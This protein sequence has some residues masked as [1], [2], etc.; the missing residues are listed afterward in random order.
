MTEIMA[1]EA[2][3]T[4]ADEEEE[5]A[6]LEE[7]A[8]VDGDDSIELQKE[9]TRRRRMHNSLVGV[10]G[11]IPAWGMAARRWDGHFTFTYIPTLQG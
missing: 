11:A 6:G 1:A 9:T 3:V 8:V 5:A 7:G 10:F 2:A 4:V